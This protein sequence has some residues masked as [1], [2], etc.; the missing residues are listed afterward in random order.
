MKSHSRIAIL[1]I[2][3]LAVWVGTARA[4]RVLVVTV[5]GSEQDPRARAVEE[6]VVFWNRALEEAGAGVRFGTV[7]FAED[8]A[9]ERVLREFR[10]GEI[11]VRNDDGLPGLLAP[12]DG[13]VIVAL[14]DADIMSFGTP[15][16][17]RA[18]GFV[19]LRR[20]DKPPISL[21]NVA[22][23]A[24]A[25]ELG[26]ALGLDHNADPAMLMCGRPASCRPDDFT[27]DSPRFFPLTGAEKKRLAALWPR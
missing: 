10:R 3:A 14:T 11:N 6:A 23:N 18:K 9:A 2:L 5:L 1:G 20:G 13:D 17:R 24:A 25:H 21:P 4:D 8:A 27:S 12:I 15:W 7:R 26:H 22:R 19:A 16:S